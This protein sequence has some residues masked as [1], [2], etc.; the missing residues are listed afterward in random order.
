MLRRPPACQVV[1]DR[2]LVLALARDEWERTRHIHRK[3]GQSAT[4]PAWE[5]LSPENRLV[6]IKNV[7]DFV[8]RLRVLESQGEHTP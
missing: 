2:A 4:E 1:D 7:E 3:H 5:A 6:W 8:K